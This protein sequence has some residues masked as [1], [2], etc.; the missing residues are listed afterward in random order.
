MPSYS[1]VQ[2]GVQGTASSYIVYAVGFNSVTATGGSGATAYIATSTGNGDTYVGTSTTSE[3]KGATYDIKVL[4]FGRVEAFAGG[5]TNQSATLTRAST[6]DNT[7][8][9]GGGVQEIQ[10]TGYDDFEIGFDPNVTI[11]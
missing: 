6:S 1:F 5:G 10:G 11:T 8:N 9:Y 4:N 3:V 7:H 2:S